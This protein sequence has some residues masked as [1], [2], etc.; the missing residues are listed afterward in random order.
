DGGAFAA[1]LGT[2]SWSYGL[3]TSSLAAG[4][5]T[6]SARATDS[7][8][9]VGTATLSFSVAGSTPLPAG[10]VEQLVTPEG[11]TIQIYSG[12]SGW[13][14]QQVYALLKANALELARIG[15]TLTIKVQ[16]T[17]ASSTS[18]SASQS[19]GVYGNYRATIY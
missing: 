7:S 17:Y 6:L 9:N 15:P 11:A 10:V 1:A 8:G 16:T 5:H 13:T 12:V 3:V 19:N 18:A 14:A 4:S 2:T